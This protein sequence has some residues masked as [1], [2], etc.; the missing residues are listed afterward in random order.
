MND[1]YDKFLKIMKSKKIT[2]EERIILEKIEQ[3]HQNYKKKDD[4]ERE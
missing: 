2:D 3:L 4:I 1:V